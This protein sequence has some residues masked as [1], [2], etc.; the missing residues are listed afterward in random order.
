MYCL[1]NVMSQLTKSVFRF[2]VI[3]QLTEFVMSSICYIT[4]NEVCIVFYMLE[5]HLTNSVLSL[6]SY[7]TVNEVCIVFY[8]LYHS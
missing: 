8:M 4:A 5:S 2:Y 3:S 6:I 1:L 7:I